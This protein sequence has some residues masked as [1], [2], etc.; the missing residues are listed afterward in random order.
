MKNIIA[1][2]MLIGGVV[3]IIIGASILIWH[4]HARAPVDVTEV[5]LAFLWRI[6]AGSIGIVSGTILAFVGILLM[7]LRR[8]D[9]GPLSK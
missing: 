8:R 6:N 3:L 7:Q 5:I 9:S 1:I 4:L 2:I